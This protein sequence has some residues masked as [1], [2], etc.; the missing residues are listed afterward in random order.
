MNEVSSPG[1]VF[2]E[3][4]TACNLRCVHCRRETPGATAARDELSTVQAR[5]F[6]SE[7]A[8]WDKPLVIFSGGEPLLR[9]DIFELLKFA[10]G[11]GLRTAVATN[12]TCID[13]MTAR[14]LR[15]AGAGRVSVSL[16]GAACA[17]HD[18]LRGVPG[19][20]DAAV[21]GLRVLRE[22]G[23]STQVNMTVCRKNR[24]DIGPLLSYA[25]DEGIDALHLFLFVPVGCGGDYG[26]EGAL[27]PR[28]I[29]ALMRWYA[30][31]HGPSPREVRI[32][33]APQYRRFFIEQG[34]AIKEAPAGCLAGRSVCFVSHR[35][36]VFPCGYLPVSAGNIKERPLREIWTT[37]D[38]FRRL[39]EPEGFSEP[40]GSCM[41]R[42]DCRGCRA[43]AYAATGEYV[44][45]DP[46]CGWKQPERIVSEVL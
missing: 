46:S 6:L 45:G 19:A 38:L 37:A 23:L 41:Y 24:A 17:T 7:L 8:S 42:D 10:N 27:K 36:E 31:Y 18:R 16:D 29:E 9:S 28:E 21:R 26:E 12:G 3:T 5:G 15:D 40:C 43:R 22:A 4:T 14:R 25:V 20:F 39:R 1:I 32:T 13:A 44:A 35:G 2:W 30:T 33:C 11:G 34:G